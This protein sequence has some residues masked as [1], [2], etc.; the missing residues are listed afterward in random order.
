MIL[1]GIMQVPTKPVVPIKSPGLLSQ[2]Y[3]LQQCWVLFT[4]V[5]KWSKIDWPL[6]AAN[7]FIIQL[8]LLQPSLLEWTWC[9]CWPLTSAHEKIWHQVHA[10]KVGSLPFPV[11]ETKGLHNYRY[12]GKI[13]TQTSPW[14]MNPAHGCLVGKLWQTSSTLFHSLANIMESIHWGNLFFSS[15]HCNNENIQTHWYW[16]KKSTWTQPF[17]CNLV[18]KKLHFPL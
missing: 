1:V 4:S 18:A 11:L 9:Y 8:I 6:C 7:S 15:K 17:G 2:I 10:T 5:A 12:L 16:K 14:I 3:F 13:L